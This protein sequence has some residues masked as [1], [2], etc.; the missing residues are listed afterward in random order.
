MKQTVLNIY[1]S[2]LDSW[3]ACSNEKIKSDTILS[4][5]VVCVGSPPQH[6]VVV[7]CVINVDCIPKAYRVKLDY[8]YFFAITCQ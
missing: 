6:P 3:D 8:Y 1:F 4:F 2:V 5:D 7:Q